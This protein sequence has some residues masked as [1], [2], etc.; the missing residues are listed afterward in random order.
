M[1]GYQY[2]AVFNNGVGTAT[3]ARGHAHD[4]SVMTPVF[5]P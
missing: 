1:N 2:E 3:T 4:Y 5:N